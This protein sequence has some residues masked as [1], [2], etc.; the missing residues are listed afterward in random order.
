MPRAVPA[1]PQIS[2]IREPKEFNRSLVAYVWAALVP[3][4][5]AAVALS[6]LHWRWLGFGAVLV[7]VLLAVA[8]VGRLTSKAGKQPSGATLTQVATGFLGLLLVVVGAI[9]G[10]REVTEHRGGYWLVCGWALGAGIVSWVCTGLS[11]NA[12]EQSTAVRNAKR[13]ADEDQR[14]IERIAGRQWFGPS[15]SPPDFMAPL[16]ALPALHGFEFP[17]GNGTATINYALAAAP[18]PAGCH[19][20]PGDDRPDLDATAASWRGRL[21]GR[22][23][24][25]KTI[26]VVRGY[27]LPVLRSDEQFA[28]T[29]MMTTTFAFVDTVGHWLDNDNWIVLPTIRNLL[30]RA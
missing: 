25:V 2:E 26:L 4:A 12:D 17:A 11:I 9:Y 23:V 14:V 22:G 3:A 1:Q 10:Y 6:A 7:L 27:E 18:G 16:F 5:V 24:V 13:N 8:D 21:A 19:A 29:T 20:R 30:G 28:L 15:E